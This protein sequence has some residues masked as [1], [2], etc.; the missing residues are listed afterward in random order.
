M[1]KISINSRSVVLLLQIAYFICIIEIFC[2]LAAWSKNNSDNFDTEV[3][4]AFNFLKFQMD[5]CIDNPPAFA[6]K[7]IEK[8]QSNLLD[9]ARFIQSYAY[10]NCNFGSPEHAAYL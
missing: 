2:P 8:I 6:D 9:S 4:K 7:N 5:T 1:S 3:V 10:L